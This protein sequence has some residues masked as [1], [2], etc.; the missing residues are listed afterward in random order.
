[1]AKWRSCSSLYRDWVCRCEQLLRHNTSGRRVS[2]FSRSWQYY[3]RKCQWTGTKTNEIFPDVNVAMTFGRRGLN[4][5]AESVESGID[6]KSE[7]DIMWR[8]PAKV[9]ALG[10]SSGKSRNARGSIGSEGR[11][12]PVKNKQQIRFFAL[13]RTYLLRGGV[14]RLSF[15]ES[16]HPAGHW[17]RHNR[18]NEDSSWSIWDKCQEWCVGPSGKGLHVRR[19][20][21]SV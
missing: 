18:E 20:R 10:R 14:R 19:D 13:K 9:A 17:S 1:M 3:G 15:G 8:W 6:E 5:M 4:Y 2:P 21:L 11:G 12:L 16:A 7:R